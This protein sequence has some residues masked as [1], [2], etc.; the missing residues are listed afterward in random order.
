MIIGP[1]VSGVSVLLGTLVGFKLDKGKCTN[2]RLLQGGEGGVAPEESFWKQSS[3][4][5]D[6]KRGHRSPGRSEVL[7]GSNPHFRPKRQEGPSSPAQ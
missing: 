6:E 4:S 5:L 1:Y 2:P 3:T 7:Q